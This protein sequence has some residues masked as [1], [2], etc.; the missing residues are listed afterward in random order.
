M[1]RLPTLRQQQVIILAGQ[2]FSNREIAQHLYIAEGTVVQ[3]LVR[4]S[5]RLGMPSYQARGEARL[6][7]YK[8]LKAY[9]TCVLHRS[10]A[11]CCLGG[12]Y[13]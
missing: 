8:K 11:P 5:R 4:G 12:I 9:D 10:Y 13:G 1:N 3:Y 6:L 2:G 7:A